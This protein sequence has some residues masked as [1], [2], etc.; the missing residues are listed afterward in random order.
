MKLYNRI[1]LYFWLITGVI[2][3][4]IV[5]IN[6]ILVGFDKWGVYLSMPLIAFLMFFFKKWMIKRMDNHMKFLESQQ[7]QKD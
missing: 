7:T 5:I 2:S 1:M 6:C 4:I 3:L